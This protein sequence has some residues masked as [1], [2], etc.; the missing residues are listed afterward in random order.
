[1]LHLHN[2]ETEAYLASSRLHVKISDTNDQQYTIPD[3][4]FERPSPSGNLN[5]RDADLQFNYQRSPFAFW[6]TRRSAPDAAPLFDTRSTSLP[7]T[8]TEAIITNGDTISLED[9]Q[10]K[11]EEQYLEVG[12]SPTSRSYRSQANVS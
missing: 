5:A 1:M 4:V 7:T 3:S 6:I 10:M 8:P 2:I 11:F 12:P 9:F